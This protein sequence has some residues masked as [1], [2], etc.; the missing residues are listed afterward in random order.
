L[1]KIKIKGLWKFGN[2]FGPTWTVYLPRLSTFWKFVVLQQKRPAR[3]A[4]GSG[5]RRPLPGFSGRDVYA[6]KNTQ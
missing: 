4:E 6:K 2:V 1:K 3:R 5:R